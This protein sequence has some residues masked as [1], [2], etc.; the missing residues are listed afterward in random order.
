MERRNEVVDCL[1]MDRLRE[2]EEDRSVGTQLGIFSAGL[3]LYVTLMFCSFFIVFAFLG[4]V[5]I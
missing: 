4:F 5:G 2:K 1:E 3:L